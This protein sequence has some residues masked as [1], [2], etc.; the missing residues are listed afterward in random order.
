MKNQ[1]AQPWLVR[2]FYSVHPPSMFAWMVP[3][4]IALTLT[5]CGGGGGSGASP[6]PA[7]VTFTATATPACALGAT[8]AAS[9]QT[10]QADAQARANALVPSSCQ[11][12]PATATA[13]TAVAANTATTSGLATLTLSVTGLPASPAVVSGG[14]LTFTGPASGGVWTMSADGKLTPVGSASVNWASSYNGT[15]VMSF[16]NAPSVSKTVT[17]ATSADPAILSLLAQAKAMI[18]PMGVQ[19]KVP[20]TE[21]PASVTKTTDAGFLTGVQNG[22]VMLID[23]GLKTTNYPNIPANSNRDV[24]FAIYRQTGA[25]FIKPIY[26]DN[27]SGSVGDDRLVLALS[28]FTF[29]RAQGAVD[30]LL[31]REPTSDKLGTLCSLAY[32]VDPTSGFSAGF[33]SKASTACP[34]WN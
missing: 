6:A 26:K 34:A 24:V 31:F 13:A 9:S 22:T 17:F 12:L 32:W 27:F 10:S 21:L 11:A 14:T 1:E 33:G 19:V 18:V 25:Y 29:D 5:A 4:A 15:L 2:C 16:A 20:A 30:G 7:P 3:V 8:P 23:T 28:G